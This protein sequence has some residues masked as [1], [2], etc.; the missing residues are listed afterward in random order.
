MFR[1]PEPLTGTYIL[2]TEVLLPKAED[3]VTDMSLSLQGS[4]SG[5]LGTDNSK[6]DLWSGVIAGVKWALLIGLLT[7][8]VAVSIGV[9]YGVMSAYFGFLRCLSVFRCYRF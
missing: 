2:R 1:R 9:I 6:R 4:V 8:A 5:I 3:T 7:A